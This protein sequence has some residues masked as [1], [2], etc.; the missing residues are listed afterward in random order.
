MHNWIPDAEVLNMCFLASDKSKKVLAG[1]V[2]IMDVYTSKFHVLL[3]RNIDDNPNLIEKQ[4]TILKIV[5]LIYDN[6]QKIYLSHEYW[7][8]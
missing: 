1:K 8:D 7:L 6:L 3:F 4:I 5:C 2:L